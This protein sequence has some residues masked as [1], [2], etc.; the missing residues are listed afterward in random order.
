[1]LRYAEATHSAQAM[2][3]RKVQHTPMQLRAWHQ[4][5]AVAIHR[6]HSHISHTLSTG[7]WCDA[8]H[9]WLP[10]EACTYHD[11][12]S[13]AFVHYVS[14]IAVCAPAQHGSTTLCGACMVAPVL[15][16]KHT[17]THIYTTTV[18]LPAYTTTVV[19][20]AYGISSEKLKKPNPTCAVSVRSMTRM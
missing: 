7:V 18:V 11:G 12:P 15:R 3:W 5:Y 8:G 10:L 17:H 16:L 20:P 19:L 9:H 6:T 1:M 14:C 13:H 4:P 2:L